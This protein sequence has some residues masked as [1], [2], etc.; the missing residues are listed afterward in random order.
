MAQY[1]TVDK[2]TFT[3]IGEWTR[4]KIDAK[5]AELTSAIE[6][7]VD[8]VEGSSLATSAQLKQIETNK[9]N[10]ESKV[11]KELGKSLVSDTDITQITTNKTDIASLKTGKADQ[12]DLEELTETVSAKADSTALNNKVDKVSGK[13][14]VDDTLITQITTNQTAIEAI[15]GELEGVDAKLS[16]ISTKMEGAV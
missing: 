2:T 14:L 3:E 5:G 12:S 4:E 7:K 1:R 8:K 10:I 11:D 9:T 16:Q 6:N 13:S 15:Q